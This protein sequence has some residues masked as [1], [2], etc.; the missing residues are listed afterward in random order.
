MM[1]KTKPPRMPNRDGFIQKEVI[2]KK[3]VVFE[4]PRRGTLY[5]KEA[6]LGQGGPEPYG[7]PIQNVSTV[8]YKICRGVLL[9]I[10]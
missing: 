1:N 8:T 5:D 2:W 6:C 4:Y 9:L 3:N 7:Q 10:V